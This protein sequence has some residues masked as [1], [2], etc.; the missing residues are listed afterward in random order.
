MKFSTFINGYKQMPV[1]LGAAEPIYYCIVWLGAQFTQKLIYFSIINSVFVYLYSLIILRSKTYRIFLPLFLTNFYFLFLIFGAE[2][3]KIAFILILSAVV[4]TNR[5]IIRNSFI[6]LSLLSHLSSILFLVIPYLSKL[7]LIFLKSMSRIFIIKV[8]KIKWFL[9]LC[10]FV[11]LFYAILGNTIIG[12]IMYYSTRLFYIESL[13]VFVLIFI[14][15]FSVKRKHLKFV[16]TIL[17]S[18]AFI[19]LFLGGTGRFF[20]FSFFT[21]TFF[22]LDSRK[23]SVFYVI[24][25]IYLSLKSYGFIH[26]MVVYGN[27]FYLI[28]NS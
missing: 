16:I 11:T 10:F 20:L 23:V 5:K 17:L 15:V 9:L 26:D 8:S 21:L 4:F 2:R 24:L 25:L 19:A 28:L 13:K 7:L 12:K 6:I 27:P 14:A 18:Y 3:N 1:I 22:I